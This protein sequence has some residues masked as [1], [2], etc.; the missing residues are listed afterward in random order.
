[1]C[2]SKWV[3]GSL[4]ALVFGIAGSLQMGWVGGP[5]NPADVQVNDSSQVDLFASQS[6]WRYQRGLPSHWKAYM[7]NR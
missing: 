6:G 2:K 5:R 7:M 4:I 3:L 1:M